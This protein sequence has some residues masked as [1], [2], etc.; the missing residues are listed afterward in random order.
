GAG[1]VMAALPAPA[2]Q[3]AA[4]SEAAEAFATNPAPGATVK[5]AR[6]VPPAPDSPEA[7]LKSR[8][9]MYRLV[10]VFDGFENA[11]IR[12][13]IK[14]PPLK[15]LFLK[16]LGA[17]K[18]ELYRGVSAGEMRNLAA[19]GW[20]Y[21]LT[22]KRNLFKFTTP[23]KDM[24]MAYARKHRG[25]LIK[26]ESEQAVPYYK[27]SRFWNPSTSSKLAKEHLVLLDGSERI[28]LVADRPSGSH[29]E[30]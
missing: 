18:A 9:P 11:C 5:I 8:G 23:D 29:P 20:R 14:T 17:E 25:Y 16:L 4:E 30:R 13:V 28:A 12:T 26:I 1:P 19:S 21:D 10:R 7:R 2:G 27:L 24:A 6:N 3:R 22:D 15:S